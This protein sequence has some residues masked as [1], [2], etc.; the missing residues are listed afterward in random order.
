M[1]KM[2]QVHWHEGLFLQPHHLQMMQR[3]VIDQF[4]AERGLA[5][6]Y[7][8]GLIEYRLSAWRTS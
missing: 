2:E 1:A 6:P 5:M 3:Q 8:W 7:P 4:G